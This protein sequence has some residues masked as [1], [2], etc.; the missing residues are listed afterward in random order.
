MPTHPDPALLDELDRRAA[1]LDRCFDLSRL[2]DS[3]DT[4]A[5]IRRYY[6]DSRLGYRLVH[7]REGAMHMALNPAGTFD[8]AGYEAQ[9]RLVEDRFAPGTADVLE[10][11]CGNGYN[12]ELL[13][14]RHRDRRFLGI[15]LVERQLAR[16]NRR[17][18]AHDNARAVPGDFQGLDLEDDAFD[19]VYV[20][21]SFCHATDLPA[22]FAEVARVLRPGG[23]FIVIDAW[24]TAA[25]D[26]L[27][28]AV[29]RAALNV[30]LAMAIADGRQLPAWQAAAA[31]AGLRVTEEVDLSAQIMP[32]LERLARVAETG[33][34]SHPWRVRLLKLVVRRPLLMNAVAGYLSPLTIM[35]GAH[36]YRLL[37]LE[38]SR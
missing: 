38:H 26:G 2:A 18:A 34:L 30:E 35:A 4:P 31:D 20:V 3:G 16:C 36:T 12:L 37:A 27:T 17:L 23:R 10:L 19:C 8:R 21:E 15:D 32:N 5:K 7:S 6:E 1:V 14:A 28:P 11:A 22:A 33:L 13:A 24:R 29:R 9:A 25:F